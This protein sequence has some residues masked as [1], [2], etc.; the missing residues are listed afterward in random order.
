M[1]TKIL[2][3]KGALTWNAPERRSDRYGTV[4]VHD[5]NSEEKK[6]NSGSIMLNEIIK[7]LVN[8][9]GT[10]LCEVLETRQSTHIGDLFHGVFPVTPAVGETVILGEGTLFTEE[11]FNSFVVGLKPADGRTELWLDINKLYRVHEQTVNL[12]FQPD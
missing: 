2:I 6:I 9:K 5:L 10:L 1:K 7:S 4:Y 3:A 12:Y 8:K 11:Q